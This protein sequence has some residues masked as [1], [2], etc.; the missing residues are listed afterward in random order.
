MKVFPSNEVIAT[1]SKKE[2]RS[3]YF[4]TVD[5]GT[6]NRASQ[7]LSIPSVSAR[8]I[9]PALQKKENNIMPR[10]LNDDRVK[11]QVQKNILGSFFGNW[12][13]ISR[14]VQNECP[15]TQEPPSAPSK[16]WQQAPGLMRGWFRCW[17]VAALLCKLSQQRLS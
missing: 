16:G 5:G 9:Y 3:I 1:V 10:K 8:D 14:S 12:K 7:A 2:V 17:E 6:G 15:S 11:S 13:C 4:S